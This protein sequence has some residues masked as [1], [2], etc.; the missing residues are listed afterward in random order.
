MEIIAHRGASHDAPENTLAAARLAWA[1]GADALE[2]DVQLTRDER[3]AVFHDDDT[4][5]LSPAAPS[6]A[7]AQLTLA[8][9]QRYDI[10]AWK[11]PRYRGEAAPALDE[12]L[13]LVPRG[14]RIFIEL[15]NGPESVP[16][17]V[18]CLARS[19]LSLAQVVVI[20]FDFAAAAAAKRALGRSEVCWIVER[21]A[22]GVAPSL[23]DVVARVHAARLDG[24]DFEN[25]WPVDAAVIARVHEA[26]LKAYVWTVDDPARASELAAAG[27]DGLTTNQPGWLREQ[28]ALQ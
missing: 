15:K 2:C 25:E 27:L 13:A 4:R 21:D 22:R 19:T 1:Q 26:R 10:G 28:L 24:I 18:R 5:R 12:L 11:N 23:D 9:L 7:V 17:L 16:E 8:E 3:L 14:R 6:R 20:S